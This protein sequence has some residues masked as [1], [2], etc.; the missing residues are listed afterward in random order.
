MPIDTDI[1]EHGRAAH[2][3]SIQI[4]RLLR[5]NLLRQCEAASRL[6]VCE[7]TLQIGVLAQGFQA[8]SKAIADEMAYLQ[9]AE[10]VRNILQPISPEVRYWS[11]TKQGRD[12]LAALP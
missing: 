3:T 11:I 6:G 10:M 2:A 12:F 4:T 8:D 5:I 9:D 1:T 7:A